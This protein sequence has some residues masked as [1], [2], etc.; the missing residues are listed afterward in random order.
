MVR[1]GLAGPGWHFL[2]LRHAFLLCPSFFAAFNP[3]LTTL[4]GLVQLASCGG[5]A[6][7]VVAPSR[8]RGRL[9]VGFVGV[10]DRLL[11]GRNILLDEAQ[12]MLEPSR[13]ERRVPKR[14]SATWAR[15]RASSA[16]MV[17]CL[18]RAAMEAQA[19]VRAD[20]DHSES[21]LIGLFTINSASWTLLSCSRA[22][23]LL[24]LAFSEVLDGLLTGLDASQVFRSAEVVEPRV[25]QAPLAVGVLRP[26]EQSFRKR[27]VS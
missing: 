18:E 22:C 15:S 19:L 12:A 5:L 1:R 10:I 25:R 27:W 14:S 23:V 13:A 21:P 17:N 9:T 26:G 20:L 3:N 24:R 6:S 2:I 4:D 16:S 8:V 7:Y 11:G